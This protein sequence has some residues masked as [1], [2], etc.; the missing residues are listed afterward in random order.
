[1]ATATVRARSKAEVPVVMP[2]RASI[3]CVNGVACG[4]TLAPW[5][6]ASCSRSQIAGDMARQT[7]PQ[8]LRIM[9]LIA[10]GRGI[11]GGDDQ[12]ALVLAV[13]VIDQDDHA[14]GLQFGQG[15]FDGAEILRIGHGWILVICSEFVNGFCER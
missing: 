4:S 1:M 5:T 2:V 9:K 14:A 15:L 11:L 3:D 8:P 7:M 6:G 10:S 12:V 13:L